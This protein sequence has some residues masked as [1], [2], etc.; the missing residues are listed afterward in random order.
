MALRAIP[1][2][3]R[4]APPA[5]PGLD[6]EPPLNRLLCPLLRIW[7]SRWAVATIRSR[8]NSIA[9]RAPRESKAPALTMLS[10]VRRF[11]LAAPARAQKSSMDEKGPFS[12]RSSTSGFTA[13]SPTVLMAASPKRSPGAPSSS[14][15][16]EKN[17]SERLTSGSQMGMP[18]RKHSLMELMVLSVLSSRAFS[19][20]AMYSTG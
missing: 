20:A 17:S 5:C 14:W 1:G 9:P 18:S 15:S 3:S 7:A 4:T 11:R 10:N 2:S 16:I 8:A 19:T 6:E 13:P 12:F